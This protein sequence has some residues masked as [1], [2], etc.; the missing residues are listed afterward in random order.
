MH[1]YKREMGGVMNFDTTYI[2]SEVFSGFDAAKVDAAHAELN[3][4]E[5]TVTFT[6]FSGCD[7][8]QYK[9]DIRKSLAK[10]GFLYNL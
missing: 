4:E 5:D 10:R 1:I 8:W 9:V 6:L 7:M 3:E 2:V